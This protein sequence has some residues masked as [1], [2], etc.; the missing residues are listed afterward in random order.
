MSD[1]TFELAGARVSPE[2]GAKTPSRISFSG[3]GALLYRRF[4]S[5]KGPNPE[6]ATGTEIDGLNCADGECRAIDEKPTWTVGERH[7]KAG[8]ASPAL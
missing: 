3:Y 7:R 5:R 1:S 6:A 8:P 4:E 2:D